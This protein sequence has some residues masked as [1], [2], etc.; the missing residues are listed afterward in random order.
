LAR[1]AE[2][3]SARKTPLQ[4]SRQNRPGRRPLRAPGDRYSVV[5]YAKAVSRACEAA[6]VEDLAGRRPELLGPVRVAEAAYRAA[7]NAWR[8]ADRIARRPLRE[9]LRHAER[10]YREAVA[11]AAAA[12]D[13]VRHWHPNQ[14]RHGHGT[15]VRRRYGLEG[16][17][18]ALGHSKADV[19]QVYAE[20]D[21]AL[22]ERIAR[23]VG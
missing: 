23:E 7:R 5:S 21:L 16:A 12:G 11:A 15:E 4:P 19:T 6:A 1:R 8:K 13:S 9:Q 14:L 18:V 17:Q 20:R 2:R 3:R 10:A 22:A